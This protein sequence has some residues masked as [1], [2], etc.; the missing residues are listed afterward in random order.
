MFSLD[1]QDDARRDWQ[2]AED[3]RH[4]GRPLY[5]IYENIHFY[6]IL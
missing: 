4:R 3:S 2:R 6:N 1:R 5:L